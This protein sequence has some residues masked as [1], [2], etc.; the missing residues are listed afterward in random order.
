MDLFANGSDLVNLVLNGSVSPGTPNWQ[1]VGGSSLAQYINH[2]SGT[3]VNNG[4]TIFGFYLNTVGGT[5]FTTTQQDL[6]L[7]RD[8]GT[9]ILSGGNS[10]LSNVNIY[11]D[12]PDMVTVVATNIG[13]IA[14]NINARMSWTEA[15]A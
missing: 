14:A 4:E 11:P 12:G 5:G 10:N 13:A 15:Q 3:V 8:L 6:T 9:S 1:S 2:S 7:V